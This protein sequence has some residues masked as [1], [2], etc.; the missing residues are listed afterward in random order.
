[1][2]NYEK[3]FLKASFYPYLVLLTNKFISI[4]FNIDFFSHFIEQNTLIPIWGNFFEKKMYIPLT[5]FFDKNMILSSLHDYIIL[6]YL[7]DKSKRN[8]DLCKQ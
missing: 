2:L 7:Y 4:F 5:P 3:W 8:D 6:N 1:M